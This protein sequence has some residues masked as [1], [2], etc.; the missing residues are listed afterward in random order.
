M[1]ANKNR[2]IGMLVLESF[3]ILIGYISFIV[4]NINIYLNILLSLFIAGFLMYLFER[5]T[6]NN[7]SK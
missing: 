5:R 6:Y 4:F 7:E 2:I 3:C 1:K